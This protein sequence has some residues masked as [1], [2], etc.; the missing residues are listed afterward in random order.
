MSMAT[1]TSPFG[2]WNPNFWPFPSY[3]VCLFF[4]FF[5]Q[6]MKCE[7]GSLQVC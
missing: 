3:N 6:D 7:G 1:M 5:K 4:V 2:F